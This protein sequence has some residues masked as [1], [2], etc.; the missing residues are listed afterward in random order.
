MEQPKRT[1][2]GKYS[3]PYDPQIRG[4]HNGQGKSD[5]V[6][7]KSVTEVLVITGLVFQTDYGVNRRSERECRDPTRLDELQLK[8]RSK[9]RREDSRRLVD[10]EGAGCEGLAG[11]AFPRL[12]DGRNNGCDHGD[13]ELEDPKNKGYRSESGSPPLLWKWSDQL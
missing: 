5:P 7:A 8:T 2:D 10:I 9:R 4:I 12:A 3:I 11:D 6:C 1:R 13:E